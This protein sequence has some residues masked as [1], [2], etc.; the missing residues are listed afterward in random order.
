MSVKEPS[1]LLRTSDVA[2]VYTFL[3]APRE[4]SAVE[5]TLVILFCAYDTYV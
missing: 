3:A 1:P 2:N 5:S 4:S